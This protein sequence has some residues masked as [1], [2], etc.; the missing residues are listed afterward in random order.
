MWSIFLVY[1]PKSYLSDLLISERKHIVCEDFLKRKNEFQWSKFQKEIDLVSKMSLTKAERILSEWETELLERA[2]Y[3]KS[4]RYHK[5]T[6]HEDIQFKDK[7]MSDTSK[8]WTQYLKCL[9]DV[10]DEQASVHGD[11]MESLSDTGEL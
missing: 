2:E 1:H 10:A 6:P 7:M 9:K 4:I 5:D 3:L 8:L 11:Q